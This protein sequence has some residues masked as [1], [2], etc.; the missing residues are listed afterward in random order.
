MLDTSGSMAGGKLD[1]AKK[2][3]R[4]CLANLNPE[5]RFEV[6]RF[7]TEAEGRFKELVAADAD[8]LAKATAMVDSLKPI[9]GTAIG[10]ALRQALALRQAGGTR[11][12]L[13]IFLTDGLP[14]VGETREDPLVEL[15]RKDNSAATRIFSFGIGDDVNT[16]LLDRIATETR[17]FSQYVSPKEDL[18][19]K[20]SNFYSKI[21]EPV[22]SNLKLAFT[23][24]DIQIT[25]LQPGM[26]P[27]LFNGDMLV[28]FGRYTGSGAAAVK[29]SGTFNGEAREFTADVTLAEAAA[30]ND[31]IPQLWATR[32]VGWLLDEIR[33]RGESAELIEETTRLARQYGIVT[34]Y[35][36]YLILEDERKRGVPVAQRNMRELESDAVVLR[37]AKTRMDSL[38]REAKAESSRSGRTATGNAMSLGGLK[39][40]RAAVPA[41]APVQHELAKQDASRD[42]NQGYRNAQTQNYATQARNLNGRAFYQNGSVWTDSTAQARPNL[43]QVNVAFNSEAYF[44]LLREHPAASQWLSL[45]NNLDLVLGDT[46]YQIRDR[47]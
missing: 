22:F 1:Q 18:E 5:D 36:A 6:I 28:V 25:Q 35:T 41:A 30:G 21:K 19:V 46:L 3:L 11:P 8:H 34:P 37:Q 33:L 44:A 20:L 43:K 2:A 12:Y 42:R 29:I 45:G 9:G 15:V 31:Y 40:Q 38:D 7:A 27:D 10:D 23:N 32:R 17:A 39:D 16:H 4:F 24:P 47:G 14:T 26:L 13:V